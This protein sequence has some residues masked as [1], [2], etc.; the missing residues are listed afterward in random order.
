M[1]TLPNP[2]T[3]KDAVSGALMDFAR[4]PELRT[5]ADELIDRFDAKF[6]HLPQLRID[7]LW[8]AEGGSSKGKMRLGQTE[9]LSGLKQWYSSADFVVW[10]AVDNLQLAAAGEREIEA[11]L[12]HELCHIGISGESD[13]PTLIPH[14]VEMFADEVRTYGIWKPDL[15]CLRQLGLFEREHQEILRG[16]LEAIDGLVAA[17]S[18]SGPRGTHYHDDKPER[19]P[20]VCRDPECTLDHLPV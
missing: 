4:A 9:K 1:A 10:L 16:G 13:Q 18:A 3:F 19:R 5:L 8:K 2:D 20:M 12:F 11:T 6:A 17:R 15:Q 14:D 7:Y